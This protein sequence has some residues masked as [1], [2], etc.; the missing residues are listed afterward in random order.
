VLTVGELVD[1]Q[2]K[3]GVAVESSD[4]VSNQPFVSVLVRIKDSSGQLASRSFELSL[5]EFQV[6]D[7]NPTKRSKH[8]YH[9]I[10]VCEKLQ[11]NSQLDGKSLGASACIFFFPSHH[12]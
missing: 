5:Q 6:I 12:L 8:T 11:R 2:W 4:G 3:L 7:M 1:M 10:G 9:H